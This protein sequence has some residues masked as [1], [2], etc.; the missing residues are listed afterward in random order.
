MDVPVTPWARYPQLAR[1]RVGRLLQRAQATENAAVAYD[2]TYSALL[3][4]PITDAVARCVARL[5]VFGAT[6]GS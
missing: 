3:L 1:E 2:V 6:G 5:C 4:L